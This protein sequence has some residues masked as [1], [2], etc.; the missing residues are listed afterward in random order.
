M[1]HETTTDLA[2]PHRLLEAVDF[3]CC[4]NMIRDMKRDLSYMAF[5]KAHMR[6]AIWTCRSGKTNKT[7]YMTHRAFA[8]DSAR[9]A[10][11]NQVTDYIRDYSAT[12]WDRFVEAENSAPK[13]FKQSSIHD[14]FKK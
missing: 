5:S 6:E 3:H 2:K 13:R 14:F 10:L 1:Y 8:E 12:Y 11:Y 9:L 7:I 4:P